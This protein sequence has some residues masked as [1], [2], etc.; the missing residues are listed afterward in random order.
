VDEIQCYGNVFRYT[1]PNG[2]SFRLTFSADGERMRMEGL[3]G[4]H[5]GQTLEL[6]VTTVRVAPSVYFVSWIK[7]DRGT[8]SQVQDYRNGV[9]HSYWT[10]EQDGQRTGLSAA[11]AIE[12]ESG[13]A[14]RAFQ[15]QETVFSPE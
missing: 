9:V 5:A 2:W 13:D 3:S 1:L 8:V 10:F 4:E 6:A 14:A 12:L 7:P 15:G 11:G